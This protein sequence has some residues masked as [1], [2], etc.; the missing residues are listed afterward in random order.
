MLIYL[1]K[2]NNVLCPESAM[3]AYLLIRGTKES[4]LFH[5]KDSRALTKE[6][7]TPVIC[8]A[9]TAAGIDATKYSGHSFRRGAATT[10]AEHGIEES[11]I[12]AMG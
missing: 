12:K 10:A 8:G 5:F 3:L 11:I 6:R 9:L 1:G 4:S 2:T 7:F